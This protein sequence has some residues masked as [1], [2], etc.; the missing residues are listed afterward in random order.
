MGT[1]EAIVSRYQDW[2][3]T[4]Q[5]LFA[6]GR[7]RALLGHML[8]AWRRR[9][10]RLLEI[11]C[12]PGVFL[13]FLWE[14]GFDV[15]GLDASAVMLAAARERLGNRADLHLGRAEELP[16]ED[17]EFDYAVLL[18]MLEFSDDPRTVLAEAVRVASRGVM[19]AVLNRF[20]LYYLSRGIPWPGCSRST[21]R[22]A[23]WQDWMRVKRWLRR[24]GA[25]GRCTARSVLPGPYSTWGRGRIWNLV[26]TPFY[27]PWMGAWCCLRLDMD[28]QRTGTT[29]PSFASEAKPTTG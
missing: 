7:E 11:G 24:A 3:E 13:H 12:G 4:P 17:D 19:V 8:S 22:R 18:T 14:S 23:N 9:G 29:L 16:Y 6:Y 25:S 10:R 21:L 1:E 28:P 26:N 5:G 27:P 2:Y 15:T 20:S